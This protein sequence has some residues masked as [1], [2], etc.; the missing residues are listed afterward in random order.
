[1]RDVWAIGPTAAACHLRLRGFAPREAE[2]L[3]ALKIRYDRGELR[4]IT[5]EDRQR[6]ARYLV[7]HGWCNDDAPARPDRAD[8]PLADLLEEIEKLIGRRRRTGR[9]PGTAP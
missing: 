4:E 9:P 1:M 7:R 3:V 5:P 6:F 2:R 8:R